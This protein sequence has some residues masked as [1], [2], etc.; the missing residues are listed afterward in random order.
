MDP[1]GSTSKLNT[2][3]NMTDKILSEHHN[4]KEDI[5]DKIE[6][7]LSTHNN[8]PLKSLP[9][10]SINVFNYWKKNE[11]HK[12]M[13]EETRDLRHNSDSSISEMDSNM[14]RHNSLFS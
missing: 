1:Y 13:V 5:L 7:G 3:T 2:N 9:I 6:K 12:N 11:P 10:N 4:K 8:T 14:C